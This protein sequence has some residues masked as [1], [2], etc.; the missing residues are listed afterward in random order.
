M[1][2]Q[3]FHV[4][5]HIRMI[6]MMIFSIWSYGMFFH[7]HTK[8]QSASVHFSIFTDLGFIYHS[9]SLYKSSL[10]WCF[11]FFDTCAVFCICFLLIFVSYCATFFCERKSS[12][13]NRGRRIFRCDGVLNRFMIILMIFSVSSNLCNSMIIKY[14]VIVFICRI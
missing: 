1:L 14:I 2:G 4:Y 8:V 12:G 6:P 13:V 9:R 5:V 11:V 10:T 7:I 3:T